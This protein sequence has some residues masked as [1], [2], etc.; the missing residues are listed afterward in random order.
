MAKLVVLSEGLTGKSCELKGEK[1][2]VGRMDDNTFQI[3]EGSISSHHCEV[4][5]RGK[6][7][8]VKDL[9][10]TNGTFVSGERVASESVLKPGQI[11]RLGQIEMRLETGE[12]V[13]SS[14][15]QFDQTRVIGGVKV[16]D[17]EQGG[18]PVFD[19][20][21]PF[22]KKSNKTAVIFLTIG[23]VLAVII[24]VFLFIAYQKLRG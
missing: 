15:K 19:K 8:V 2:T 10:S 7:V 18:R 5:L 24:V 4:L 21:S 6:D 12:A 13:P 20:A 17:F 3:T 1:T 11:L 23:I 9:N 22:A 16:G 14:K